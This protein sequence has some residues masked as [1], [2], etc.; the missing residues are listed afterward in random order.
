MGKLVVSYNP[1]EDDL[2]LFRIRLFLW[3]VE[4]P[5]KLVN[6]KVM[7][8][9]WEASVARTRISIVWHSCS[10]FL[11]PRESDDPLVFSL[12]VGYDVSKGF[13]HWRTMVSDSF[14]SVRNCRAQVLLLLVWPGGQQ[15]L[16]CS[17]RQHLPCRPRLGL[18]WK[19]AL[20]L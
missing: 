6:L 13:L 19:D 14:K 10:S 17:V 5:V 12:E 20:L 9:P 18:L 1:A 2:P 11:E 16:L 4:H 15:G 7:T 8:V 3:R